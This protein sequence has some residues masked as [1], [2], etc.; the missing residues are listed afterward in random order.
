MFPETNEAQLFFC[1][2]SSNLSF[3]WL[4]FW[5]CTVCERCVVKGQKLRAKKLTC[6]RKVSSTVDQE[7]NL[8]L[9]SNTQKVR[10]SSKALFTFLK[11]H[12]FWGGLGSN[13]RGKKNICEKE[14][15]K[16][17]PHDEAAITVFRQKSLVI[18]CRRKNQPFW[19]NT[20][21]RNS[22]LWPGAWW[23]N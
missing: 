1:C 7:Q 20:C 6:E 15:R 9:N 21:N 3:A 19:R 10:K 13:T 5:F 11:K 12:L 2:H 23:R 17:F 8:N 16:G 4:L 14:L 22:F 18:V